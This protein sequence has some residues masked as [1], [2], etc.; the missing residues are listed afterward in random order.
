MQVREA[1]LPAVADAYLGYM[2]LRITEELAWMQGSPLYAMLTPRE[3]ADD[4]PQSSILKASACLAMWC[5]TPCP[6]YCS[7]MFSG[8]ALQYLEGK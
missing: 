2:R 5:L 6:C 8:E 3:D 4:N 1:P 7:R